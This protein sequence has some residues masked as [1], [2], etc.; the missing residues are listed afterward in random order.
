MPFFQDSQKFFLRTVPNSIK[1]VLVRYFKKVPKW[2][3]TK[4]K[5]V[6][7]MTKNEHTY[8]L[9]FTI[10]MI[11]VSMV[12]FILI[13]Q[14]VMH[15]KMSSYINKKNEGDLLPC[16]GWIKKTHFYPTILVSI[17][18]SKFVV[19]SK[20]HKIQVRPVNFWTILR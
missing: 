5:P 4:P 13:S 2:T 19:L 17:R 9:Q 7:S 20:W 12:F 3:R 14:F 16:E 15:I 10:T 11:L 1:D 6:Q 8:F 18:V